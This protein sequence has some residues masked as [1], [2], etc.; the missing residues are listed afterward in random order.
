VNCRSCAHDG[1]GEVVD[2]GLMPLVNNLMRSADEV[3]ARWPLHVVFCRECSLAQL[4]ETPPPQAMFDEYLY[5]S[6][7]SQTMVE[8]ARRLV[9]RFVEPGDRVLE[10]ASND[11]YLLHYAKERVATVLGVDPASNIAEFANQRG[12]P[13][14]CEYFNADSAARLVEEWSGPADVIFANNVL[15][16]VPD[17]NEIAA[18]IAIALSRDG[19]AH[20]EVPS[21]VR[22]IESCAFD[23]IYHE[24]YSYFSLTALVDL[25]RRH[26]MKIVAVELMDVHG[27]SLHVQVAHEGH[28]G[29]AEA[30]IERERSVGVMEDGFYANFAPRVHAIHR[31]LDAAIGRFRT[32]V[33]YGAAAKGIVL[34]N[35]FGLTRDRIA[36]VA[37][38]SPH[39]Q[40]RF[41]PGTGQAIVSPDRLTAERPDA[42]LLLPWNLRE[43][44]LGRNQSYRDQGGR[45]IVPIPRV[46]IV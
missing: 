35:A 23:T 26:G 17:P 4:T 32:V 18:G 42:A 13:T 37:D 22:M 14:R 33:G 10:I 11:G 30:W 1:F 8:H 5:F 31:D 24:H 41:V 27:G 39:K 20:I 9:D 34:L 46:E 7:Q 36:W 6:S 40:G 15:A 25:F 2:L 45:F 16:H 44:V 38:V 29:A 12:I 43:E 19:V 21:L 28:E 3:A